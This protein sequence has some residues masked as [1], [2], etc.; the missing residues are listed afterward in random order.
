MNFEGLLKNRRSVRKYQDKPVAVDLILEMIEESTLAPNAGNE[1]PWKF[2]IVNNRE[3]LKKISDESKRNILARIAANPN[4][5]AKKYQGMLENESFNV[6]YNA[7]C[8]VMILGL[9]HL[10]NLFVDCALAAGYFMMAASS[11]GL[12]TCW[13]NLGTEIHDPE[14]IKE[15]GIPDNCTIVAPIILGYSEKIPPVPKRNEPK[16]LKIIR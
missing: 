9:S 3:M 7:S 8:L 10:K 4:D 5:Y 6:F 2:V 12:G 16:I 11:R 13:V 15:L 14:M 1:Q